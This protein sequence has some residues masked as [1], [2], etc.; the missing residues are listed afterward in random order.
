MLTKILIGKECGL[1]A[2]DRTLDP[3]LIIIGIGIAQIYYTVFNDGF[4]R[5]VFAILVFISA[6]EDDVLSFGLFFHSGLH[7]LIIHPAHGN[8]AVAITRPSQRFGNKTDILISKLYE[9]IIAVNKSQLVTGLAIVKCVKYQLRLC[10]LT[11]AGNIVFHGIGI[12]HGS[13]LVTKNRLREVCY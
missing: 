9:R 5:Q 6:R 3:L 11:S 1:I 12:E 2:D 10:V 8:M 4:A 7:T 13:V